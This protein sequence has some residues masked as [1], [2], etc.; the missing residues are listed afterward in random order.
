MSSLKTHAII[1]NSAAGLSAV[2]AIR[3]TGDPG[4]IVLISAENCNAYSPVLTTYYIGGE[5]H[6][7]H[8][9]LVDD[10]FYRDFDVHR[11]F[12]RRAVEIDPISRVVYL[13]QGSKAGYDNLLI[14]T[15]ASARSLDTVD[16][17]ASPYV[18]TLRTIEDAD[19][20]KEACENA[21]EIVV[22]GAGLVSLQFIKAI[23]GRGIKITVLVGSEQVLSQ[24]MDPES[25]AI[26]QDKLEGKGVSILF[27]RSVERVIRRGDRAHVITN[28]GEGLS[29][30]LVVVG[31]G[32]QPN[33]Q[34]V[35]G[36]EI[37]VNNGIIVDDRMRTNMEGIFAAGDVA[38]GRNAITGQMEVIATWLNACAQGEIAGLNMAGYPSERQGQFRENITTILGVALASIGVSRPEEGEFREIRYKDPKRGVFRKLSFEGSKVVGA[39]LLG[40]IEDAG[41]IRHCIASGMDVS[42]WEEKIAR[43]PLDFGRILGGHDF[44]WPFFKN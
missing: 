14:A 35:K 32:V 24:Q 11:V 2:K 5:I 34:L 16:A 40:S 26:I 25:A 38:E 7:S 21:K 30:D 1:G 36:T 8:L 28:F 4:R 41:V 39:L 10:S 33:T 27:G 44:G 13:D 23:V 17:D 18:S 12:G 3:K 29:A 42:L 43:A 9:F 37:K 31:K 22:T 20:I 19:R 6:R 15:G